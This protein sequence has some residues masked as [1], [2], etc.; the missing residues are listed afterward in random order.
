MLEVDDDG[1]L[2]CELEVLLEGLVE[3][4][5]VPWSVVLVE[6][7]LEALG[8]AEFCGVVSGM[9]DGV[10]NGSAVRGVVVVAGA[11][12]VELGACAAGRFGSVAVD[13]VDGCRERAGPLDARPRRAVD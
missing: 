4:V 11:V 1:V 10:L 2:D 6:L 7:G 12:V 13:C 8:L 3:V 9:V 5:E